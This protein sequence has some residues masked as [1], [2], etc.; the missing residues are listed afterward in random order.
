MD[1]R[2]DICKLVDI[3]LDIC[4]LVDII[5]DICK[6]VDIRLGICKLVDIRLC[7]MQEAL[8]TQMIVKLQLRQKSLPYRVRVSCKAAQ[9]HLPRTPTVALYTAII[10]VSNNVVSCK[11]TTQS[12]RFDKDRRCKVPKYTQAQSST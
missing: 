6:L 3:R 11:A 8:R 12:N 9:T 5:L 7:L 4:K 1:I 10:V 2:L